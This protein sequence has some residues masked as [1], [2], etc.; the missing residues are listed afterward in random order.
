MAAAFEI[1]EIALKEGLILRGKT[2]LFLKF[3]ESGGRVTFVPEMFDES[4][5]HA[6][7]SAL[8]WRRIGFA[9]Q[10]F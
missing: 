3:R 7:K 4:F 2:E 10:A 5:F 1:T 8:S 6:W 9:C